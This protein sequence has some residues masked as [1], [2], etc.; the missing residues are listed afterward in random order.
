MAFLKQPSKLKNSILA[1][2]KHMVNKKIF[3]AF[4]LI[5][6]PCCV[7]TVSG[8]EVECV[9]TGRYN[10]T[11]T[12]SN[13]FLAEGWG[14][15]VFLTGVG[16]YEF[17]YVGEIAGNTLIFEDVYLVSAGNYTV[18]FNLSFPTNSQGDMGVIESILVDGNVTFPAC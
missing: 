3:Y 15:Q 2:V 9:S 4:D 14:A 11:A 7:P 12:L 8:V 16:N 13:S 10:I 18:G 5:L 1:Y 17:S 6:S